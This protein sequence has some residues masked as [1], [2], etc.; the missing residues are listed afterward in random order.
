MSKK[1]LKNGL[2][3][4]EKHAGK[5]TVT[6]VIIDYTTKQY[7]NLSTRSSSLSKLKRLIIETHHSEGPVP[8]EVQAMKLTH[9]QYVKLSAATQKRLEA[10]SDECIVIEDADKFMGNVLSGLLGSTVA[11]LF[12]AI[13][14]ACGRRTK[15]ILETGLLTPIKGDHYRAI[16]SGQAKTRGDPEPFEIPLLSPLPLVNNAIDNLRAITDV[17]SQSASQLGNAVAKA[18][19]TDDLTPHSLRAIYSAI[20]WKQYDGKKSMNRYIGLILGHNSMSTSIHYARVKIKGLT[21]IRWRP[22]ITAEMFDI[23]GAAQARC[24][25]N[26]VKLYNDRKRVTINALRKMQSS[27]STIKTVTKNNE[28]LVT[29]LKKL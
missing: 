8:K 11:E 5:S 4:Y 28:K 13:A 19:C 17:K 10:K 26:I 14:L 6:K 27:P 29:V 22:T 12:P 16:F 24:V 20:L 9:A 1:F 2:E 23:G 18:T 3:L 21:T 7:S 15:E 25:D